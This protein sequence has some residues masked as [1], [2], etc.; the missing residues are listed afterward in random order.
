[1]IFRFVAIFEG[2]LEKP[3]LFVWGWKKG[4]PSAEPKIGEEADHDDDGRPPIT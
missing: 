2:G 3:A 1:M 4:Q